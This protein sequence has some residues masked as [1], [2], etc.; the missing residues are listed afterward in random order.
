[1]LSLR[2]ERGNL[3]NSVSNT[4]PQKKPVIAR[5]G[6]EG[7]MSRSRRTRM[8]KCRG[9]KDAHERPRK[10][11]SDV[12]QQYPKPRIQQN[13]H[14]NALYIKPSNIAVINDHEIM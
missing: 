13:K 11:E 6:Q 9:C 2:V 12:A 8:F 1:M 10:G 4:T 5:F 14:N 7:L 3:P